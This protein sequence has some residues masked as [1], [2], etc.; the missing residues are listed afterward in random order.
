MI[1]VQ[2]L[3]I[4][5]TVNQDFLESGVGI[6]QIRYLMAKIITKQRVSYEN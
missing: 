3:L 4:N 5:I 2:K 6:C 1:R